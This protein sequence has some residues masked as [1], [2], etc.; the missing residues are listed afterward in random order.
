M[1]RVREV[2]Q[3]RHEQGRAA[4]ATQHFENVARPERHAFG[5]PTSAVV[6]KFSL[7][8][9]S[10]ALRLGWDDFQAMPSHAIMRA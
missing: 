2:P 10:A 7:S 3:L 5:D 1:G 8:D 9:L 4:M 6:R